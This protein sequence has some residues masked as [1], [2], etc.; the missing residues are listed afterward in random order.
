MPD[1]VFFKFKGADE[2]SAKFKRLTEAA[3]REIALPAAKDA[4]D[5]VLKDAKDRADRIDDPATPNYIPANLKLAEQ[6]SPEGSVRVAVGLKRG[7]RGSK[8][9]NTYYALLFV[10]LGTVHARPQP[11][12]RNALNQNKEAVFKEFLS[13]AKFN[14]LRVAAE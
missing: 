1:E 8:G 4:M 14:L 5:I 13:S 11:F 2:L 12:L 6:D 9:G 3:R 10:E 7:R